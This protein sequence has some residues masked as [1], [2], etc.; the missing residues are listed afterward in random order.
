MGVSITLIKAIESTYTHCREQ[1]RIG[2]YTS[3]A[4]ELLAGLRQG[5]VLSPI[6]FVLYTSGL[7]DLLNKAPHGIPASHAFFDLICALMFVDDLLTISTTLMGLTTHLDIVTQWALKHH[8]VISF[9]KSSMSSASLTTE[10]L[11]QLTTTV[12]TLKYKKSFVYLGVLINLNQLKAGYSGV[13]QDVAHRVSQATTMIK[14]MAKRGLKSGAVAILPALHIIKS[15]TL[16]CITY[17]L[18]GPFLTEND[19][20]K[21]DSTVASAIAHLLNIPIPLSPEQ[22]AWLLHDKGMIPPTTQIHINDCTS[23]IKACQGTTDLITAALL[24]NDT[25][26]TISVNTFLLSIATTRM[27]I[28]AIRPHE[29]SK[30]LVARHRAATINCL[31]P[32]SIALIQSPLPILHR[33]KH[34]QPHQQ[35]ALINAR[36]NHSF[37][38]AQ[39]CPQCNQTTSDINTHKLWLCISLTINPKPHNLGPQSHSTLIMILNGHE[40]PD[41]PQGSLEHA[42]DLLSATTITL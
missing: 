19:K 37:P 4:Y 21:L 15:T 35:A 32:S 1:I 5:S 26:L 9:K 39:T 40:P 18:S 38:S 33:H 30:Y 13:G 17:G 34:L 22:T 14:A 7:L 12:T 10:Q 36:H 20:D 27:Q 23:H 29:R 2:D 31:T 16:A 41:T 11:Q 25:E 8:A 6:L 24:P 3:L 28:T 42:L